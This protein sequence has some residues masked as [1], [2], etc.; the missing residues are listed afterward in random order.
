MEPKLDLHF[1]TS[2]LQTTISRDSTTTSTNMK[3]ILILPAVAAFAAA[4]P[5]D[6]ILT[7]VVQATTTPCTLD[8]CTNPVS[9]PTSL[10]HST[11]PSSSVHPHHTTTSCTLDVCTNPVSE[12]TSLYTITSGSVVPPP[13]TPT[14]M[15]TTI[16]QGGSTV[17]TE[18]VVTPTPHP[19]QFVGGAAVVREGGFM[20]GGLLAGVALLL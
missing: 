7:G 12:P 11:T 2:Q 16:T 9:E 13:M 10:Y 3:S 1:D 15:P 18:T 4:L 8:V 19:T 5:Q 14:T 17:V 20:V 6:S